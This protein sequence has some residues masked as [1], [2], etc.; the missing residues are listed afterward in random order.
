M[1]SPFSAI[2]RAVGGERPAAAF[3]VNLPAVARYEPA[4]GGLVAR[5]PAVA[6]PRWLDRMA[7]TCS[8]RA[9]VAIYAGA[10]TPAARITVHGDGSQADYTPA[11][12][13]YIAGGVPLLVVWTTTDTDAT[14][15]ANAQ[16]RQAE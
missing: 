14:A 12:P 6:Y 16:L 10:I 13:P 9:P 8:R 5:F 15:S 1:T 3:V 4:A 7:T 11:N 2:R